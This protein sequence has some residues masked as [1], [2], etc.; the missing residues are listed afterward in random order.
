[1][2]KVNSSGFYY[3]SIDPRDIL[4]YGQDIQIRDGV[5]DNGYEGIILR[6]IWN[7]RFG[8]SQRGYAE[9]KRFA[10]TEATIIGFEEL[11]LEMETNK[12]KYVGTH[13]RS[14]KQEGM[15]KGDWVHLLLFA[16]KIHWGIQIGAGFT[17]DQ[18]LFW[19]TKGASLVDKSVKFK[20]ILREDQQK[21]N[22]DFF[23]FGFHWPFRF[24]TD[25][26]K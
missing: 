16:K 10:D 22:Q 18:R 17:L 23:I 21:P 8:D 20:S 2:D 24:I 1:L 15:V 25:F 3:F 11:Q 12:W 5:L 7:T 19:R 4:Q 26:F 9:I 13:V 14:S 6:G